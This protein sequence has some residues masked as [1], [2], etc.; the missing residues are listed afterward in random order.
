MKNRTTGQEG[1]SQTQLPEGFLEKEVI[2][3]VKKGLCGVQGEMVGKNSLEVSV[4]TSDHFQP[5]KL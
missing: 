5:S 3:R 2:F 1:Q 4:F